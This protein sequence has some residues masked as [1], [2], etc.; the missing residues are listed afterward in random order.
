MNILLHNADN[1]TDKLKIDY[2]ALQ[3]VQTQPTDQRPEKHGN[4]TTPKEIAK[5]NMY[6][7]I[8]ESSI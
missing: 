7:G 6:I 2:E 4:R 5:M 1:H 8:S 3:Y